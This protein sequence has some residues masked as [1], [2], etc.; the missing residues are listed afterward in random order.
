MS[1]A[2]GVHLG[3]IWGSPGVLQYDL[4][5]VFQERSARSC[6][7]VTFY[8]ETRGMLGFEICVKNRYGCIKLAMLEVVSR[9]RCSLQGTSQKRN[10]VNKKDSKI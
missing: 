9:I 2:P 10:S 3:F 8:C 6:G 1:T 4:V 7:R 5:T